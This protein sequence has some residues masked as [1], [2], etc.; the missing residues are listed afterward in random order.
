MVNSG[1][2]VHV[3]QTVHTHRWWERR[4]AM[5]VLAAF[6]AILILGVPLTQWF[7][8]SGIRWFGQHKVVDSYSWAAMLL[9]LAM[10]GLS[11]RDSSDRSSATFSGISARP[12]SS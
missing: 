8:V 2:F 3:S 7:E 5:R 4:R 12:Q 1:G 10:L 6:S 11:Y 9:V